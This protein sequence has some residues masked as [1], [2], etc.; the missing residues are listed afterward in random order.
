MFNSKTF[1][2]H[3]VKDLRVLQNPNN[4][5]LKLLLNHDKALHH[6][7]CQHPELKPLAPI[8]GKASSLDKLKKVQRA[9]FEHYTEQGV[10]AEDVEQLWN[11]L[12]PQTQAADNTKASDAD[13]TK[14]SKAGKPNAS[15]ADKTKAA[16][17]DQA[18][19]G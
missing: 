11:A 17:A 9:D 2:G 13:Q 18:K 15:K 6:F 7:F 19:I 1:Y 14:V 8:F 5:M 10:T 16:D 12:H 4:E 3:D